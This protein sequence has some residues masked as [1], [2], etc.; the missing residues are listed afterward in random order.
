M[1]VCI[2]CRGKEETD[3]EKLRFYSLFRKEEK[4]ENRDFKYVMHDLTNVYIGAKYTYNELLVLDEVPFKLKTLISRFILREVD[5]NTKI[6]DHIFYL[7]E[8]DMS[9]QIYKEMKARFR[10][11]VWKDESD[12]VK[13]PGYKSSTYRIAEILG[14]EELMR[15][16]NIT[17]VEELHITKLGLMGV[18]L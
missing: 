18:A 17:I 2:S 5:G 8:T 15:K 13:T 9:Y 11:N 7:K 4:L 12:G 1:Q 6:E 3:E 16:K 10:L 14:N